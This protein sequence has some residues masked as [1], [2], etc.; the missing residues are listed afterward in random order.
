MPTFIVERT[1]PGASRMTREQ[2]REVAR[3]S[4]GVVAPLGV[5]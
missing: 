2:L 5:P 1:V 4:N 3:T